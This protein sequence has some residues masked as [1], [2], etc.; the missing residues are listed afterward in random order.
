VNPQLLFAA[1]PNT[2]VGLA[3]VA[4]GVKRSDLVARLIPAYVDLL[5]QLKVRAAVDLD[6]FASALRSSGLK[7]SRL[8]TSLGA[9]CPEL[10]PPCFCY[11]NPP[12]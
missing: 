6:Y 11:L 2:L 9:C 3:T 12:R 5:Q 7:L 4:Q 1:G 8:K 10:A